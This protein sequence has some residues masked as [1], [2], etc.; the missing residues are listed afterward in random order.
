[1][2]ETERTSGVRFAE[3]ERPQDAGPAAAVGQ[4][5][6]REHHR[7]RRVADLYADT[8]EW[9][10]LRGKSPELLVELLLETGTWRHDEHYA[11]RMHIRRALRRLSNIETPRQGLRDPYLDAIEKACRAARVLLT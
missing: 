2:T 10:Q 3:P 8:I 9:L 11:A 1:M 7:S 4:P 6:L 5:T